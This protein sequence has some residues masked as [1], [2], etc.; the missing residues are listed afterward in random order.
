MLD[1][2]VLLGNPRLRIL[3]TD[4]STTLKTLQLPYQ[5]K[6]NGV[7]VTDIWAKGIK[8]N[9]LSG[10][11]RFV[12]GGV[13]HNVS[14]NYGLYDPSFISRMMGYTVGI[15]DGNVPELTQLYTLLATYNNGRLAIS[16]CSNQDVWY[17]V[18]CTSDLIRSTTFPAAFGGVS[19]AFEGLDVFS[20]SSSTSVIG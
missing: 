20:D 7:V 1:S 16:P 13:R 9:L 19:L 4:K 11:V 15:L 2:G 10:G 6:E 12:A 17:R 18:A 8:T 14:I 5:D 3:N